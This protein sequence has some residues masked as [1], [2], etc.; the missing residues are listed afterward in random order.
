MYY[1][2]ARNGVLY[3]N[4]ELSCCVVIELIIQSTVVHS[5]PTAIGG[6]DG[7]PLSLNV[8]HSRYVHR[9]GEVRF[10]ETNRVVFGDYG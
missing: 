7:E 8:R 5:L 3:S 10:R 6:A 1:L 4:I 9:L 2:H